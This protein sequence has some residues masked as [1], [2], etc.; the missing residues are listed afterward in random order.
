VQVLKTKLPC[1][2][3]MLEATNTLRRGSL[4][5]MLRAERAEIET[6]NAEA[7]GVADIGKCG[8]KGSPTKVSKV[9][10]PSP[11]AEKAKMIEGD[12]AAAK[13]TAAIDVLVDADPK[14]L[15]VI[16]RQPALAS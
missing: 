12:T 2:I 8:M 1:L 16:A 6:W 10:A 13:A 14:L 7:A 9:F 4:P 3:T 15:Q 5:D 11:R